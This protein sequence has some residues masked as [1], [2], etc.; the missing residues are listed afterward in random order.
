MPVSD[1]DLDAA[2]VQFVANSDLLKQI[3]QGDDTVTV[4]TDSGPIDSIAKLQKN[5]LQDYAHVEQQANKDASGGYAG[6]TGFKLNLQ[7]IAGTFK[8]LLSNNATAIRNWVMPDKDGTVAMIS[9]VTAATAPSEL[10]VNKDTTDGYT[11]LTGFAINL[12]NTAGNILSNISTTAT[13]ARNW[14]MPDKSGTVAMTS[15]LPTRATLAIDLVDNTSDANKPISTLTATALAARELLSNKVVD[16]TAP[17]D[18]VYPS[19]LAVKTLVDSATVGLLNDRGNWSAAGGTYPNA[20]GSGTAGAIRKGDTYFI[21][22]AGNLGGVGVNVGDSV[23]ALTNAPGQTAANWNVL[24]SN[25]GY[26]P[27]NV[28]AK[29]ATGGYAG[30]TLFK[31]N[32]MNAA[33]SVKSFFTSL[34]TVARTYTLPDKD[35]TVAMT[36]D[37]TGTNSGVNTGD[38]TTATI[39]T[40]LGVATLSGSNTGDQTLASLAAEGTANKD[41]SGGYV[42]LTLFKINFK[43]VANSF[44][45]FFTNSNTAARTYTFPDKDG[46]V[47]MISDI[48]GGTA[49]QTANKDVSGGYVGL[50]LFKLNLKNVAGTITSFFTNANTV[51]R[52]YTL[53]DKDGTVAM[54]SDTASPSTANSWTGTQSFLGSVAGAA[55]RLLNALEISNI[56]ATALNG[57]ATIFPGTNGAVQYFTAAATANFVFNVGWISGT[58]I[59]TV[60]AVGDTMTVTFLATQ[61]ATAFY[62][63]GFQVET[64]AQTVLWQGGSAPSAGTASG[65]DAY[66]FTIVKTA[67]STYKVFGS[68]VSYK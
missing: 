67:A 44:T 37:I 6:L 29:D 33:G 30:L 23:R 32:V 47:A 62:C 2:K 24:E 52:T 46:T 41:A 4:Q 21:N 7:N 66:T 3:V 13:A 18:T 39:K 56:V 38:E 26:V 28:T 59:N 51:A 22:V 19:A 45:S 12:K 34:A 8:S 61:G 43:N 40:K 64:V 11:G 48:S 14:A 58:S 16:F 57:V 49:E 1:Q 53:P 27:E 68:T 35:G 17:T 10:S 55:I 63:T 15:D 31:L 54:L 60:M 25:I 20:N 9:D 65:V 36:S 5:V 50:T 42:G